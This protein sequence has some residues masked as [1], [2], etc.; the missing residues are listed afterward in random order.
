MVSAVRPSVTPG[1]RA[2]A[3]AVRRARRVSL[4]DLRA[5]GPLMVL[6]PHP[7]D[8]A[9][10]AGP[11]LAALARTG[12][13][14][15]L[16][17]VTDGSASHPDAP[18]WSPRRLA[19]ARHG[20]GHRAA[21]A[22]G[23]R[24][25][26]VWLGWRDAAPP[27]PASREWRRTVRRL[28]GHLRRHGIRQLVTSWGGEAHCDHEASARLADAAARAARSPVRVSSVA[29]WGWTEATAAARLQ[30]SRARSVAV[31]GGTVAAAR[32]LAC[33]RSQLGTRVLASPNGF[34][35]PRPMWSL[36]RRSSL[37]LFDGSGP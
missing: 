4:A 9:L 33:H 19:H 25:P 20:E 21:V 35:L 34:R 8:E 11:L 7:D 18:G 15:H 32:A 23:L 31:G 3:G 36:A 22:L 1:A 37:L 13:D 24:R 29:V 10:G 6:A 12:G 14:P 30:R 28:G 5:G 26:P 27:A 2:W 16:A 17:F